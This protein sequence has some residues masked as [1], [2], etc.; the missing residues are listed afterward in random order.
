L[1]LKA[2]NPQL[3][4]I[5]VHERAV[6][7]RLA[8]HLE[9]SLVGW[10]V[11]CEYDRDGQDQKLLEG[12]SQCSSEKKTDRILPDII[13][14]HRGRSGP[15]N[16]LLVIEAKKDSARDAC[17]HEKLKR[18]TQGRYAYRFGLY[19]NIAGGQLACCWYE[20]GDTL[21]QELR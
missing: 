3:D 7:H 2:E 12:I 9:V 4:F 20:N 21:N 5:A 16:N 14:H 8:V 10:N 11:D 17:D 18:L 13:V 19:L 6:T 1:A 15:E